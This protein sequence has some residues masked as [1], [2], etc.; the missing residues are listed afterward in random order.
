MPH[1]QDLRL[2]ALC[3]FGSSSQDGTRVHLLI[4]FFA[5]TE[6]CAGRR[7]FLRVMEI[8][9]MIRARGKLIR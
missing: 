6:I 7:D 5:D 4:L 1:K 8:R 9:L 2:L 3:S